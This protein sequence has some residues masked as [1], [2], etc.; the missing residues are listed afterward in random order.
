MMTLK[1]PGKLYLIG[2]YAVIEKGQSAVIYAVDRFLY[3]EIEASNTMLI[4]SKFGALDQE[5][6]FSDTLSM[7][8]VSK[9]LE[10][11]HEYLGEPQGCYHLTI[12]SELDSDENKKYGFGSSGV[13]VAAVIA[14]VAKFYGKTLTNEQI[15]KLGVIA[16]YR[17][18]EL[19]SGGDLATALYGG[20]IQYTRYD[21]EWL[22]DHNGD[23]SLVDRTWPLLNVIPLT[24]DNY[25]IA[26]GWTQTE[27]R[28]SHYV[29]KYRHACI[30]DTGTHQEILKEARKLVEDFVTGWQDK[31]TILI[32]TT[33]QSYR[34]LMQR[35]A[36][37]AKIN[38]ETQ[39]LTHLIEAAHELGYVAKVSG[40]GGGD[41]GYALITDENVENLVKL[42]K[43][44]NKHDI[45]YLDVKGW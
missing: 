2:E 22:Q 4:E 41:C 5:T 43:A 7:K 33:V 31:N 14:T 38:V 29:N 23:L 44:W 39:T 16:Q 8:Y 25:K 21:N 27:N 13:V 3:T 18:N 20:V 45:L 28:T 15:F 24:K 26:V 32:E 34:E 12:K 42:N 11:V 35:I 30:E 19:S 37:W 9:A 6:M 1:F 10:V 40:S 36:S 17:L